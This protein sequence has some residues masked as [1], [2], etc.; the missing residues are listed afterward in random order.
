MIKIDFSKYPE[1]GEMKCP[2]CGKIFFKKKTLVTHYGGKHRRDTT[3]EKIVLI[4]K[5]CKERL[6]IDRNWAK[7]AQKQG[8]LICIACKRKQN[9]IS[10]RKKVANK[11][12]SKKS[13]INSLKERLKNNDTN[14]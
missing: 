13:S 3:Q 12:K 8:N 10:Y 7:W 4:C 9:R 14:S 2:E 1:Y 6:V 5:F 11:N